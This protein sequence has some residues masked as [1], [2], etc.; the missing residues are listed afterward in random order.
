MMAV[1]V[2]TRIIGSNLSGVRFPTK[3][4]K[5]ERVKDAVMIFVRLVM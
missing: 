3:R 4:S 1:A 2:A 5:T